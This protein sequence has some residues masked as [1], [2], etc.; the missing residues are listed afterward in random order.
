METGVGLR[1]ITLTRLNWPTLDT[2][3]LAQEPEMG[4][5]YF[6]SRVGATFP[7]KIFKF[8]LPW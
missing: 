8:S 1:Q 6:R 4:D 5:I 3:C 2:P 7:V